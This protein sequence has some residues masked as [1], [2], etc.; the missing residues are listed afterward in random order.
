MNKSVLLT[1]A[2]VA[3]TLSISLFTAD[4]Q[5]KNAQPQ[6]K[7]A[8][9]QPKPAEAPKPA[10]VKA[11]I[12]VNV[13]GCAM[14]GMNPTCILM[15]APAGHFEVGAAKP[16]PAL[17]GNEIRLS[18]TTTDNVSI[19]MQGVVLKDVQWSKTGNKCK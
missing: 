2:F 6:Q 14:P 8:Q 18:G 13:T 3:S 12:K 11:G 17:D 7:N 19:C 9:V 5:Q 4:A 1:V 15:K 10:A 16:A